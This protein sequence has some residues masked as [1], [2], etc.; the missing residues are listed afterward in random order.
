MVPS[1]PGSAR[2]PMFNL[3]TVVL[4]AI[5]VLVG[6]HALR[7]WV[8][9]DWANLELLLEAALVPVRW[10]AVYAGQSAET[11]IEGLSDLPDENLRALQLELARYVLSEGGGKPWTGVSYALLHGSWGHVA[12]NSIW[13]AAFGTPL[14]R[15]CGGLRF[16]GLAAATAFGGALAHVLVHPLQALPMV[17]ASAAVSGM[18]AS[19]AWFIFAPPAWLL[20][21]RL[22]QPH[23]RPRESLARTLTDRRVLVFLVVWF[24]TNYLFA[25]LARPLGITDASIAWDAHIGGFLV[26]LLL[27]PWL[28]PL[29]RRTR[30]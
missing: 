26:G 9:S 15:R 29:P 12:M 3:P 30:T 16:C 7:E 14:A 4:L 18:M 1:R 23:E 13:L 10:T 17:G 24:G 28:D 25:V 27:F 21:G 20:E 22:T 5:V 8:L 2:E 11:I 6:I 19:A